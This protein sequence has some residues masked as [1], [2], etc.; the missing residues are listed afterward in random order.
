[1]L[2]IST[3]VI[4]TCANTSSK[5]IS[6]SYTFIFKTSVSIVLVSILKAYV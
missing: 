2:I 5:A 4:S 3:K 6:S 1:M